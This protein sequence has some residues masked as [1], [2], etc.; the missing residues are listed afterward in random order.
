MSGFTIT[1]RNQH[2]AVE[3]LNS[4]VTASDGTIV[5]TTSTNVGLARSEL[6]GAINWQTKTFR[7][8]EKE[9]PWKEHKRAHAKWK[10]TADWH[11]TAGIV[12]TMKAARFRVWTTPDFAGLRI[13]D[14]GCTPDAEGGRAVWPQP[15]PSFIDLGRSCNERHREN[16][17]VLGTAIHGGSAKYGL[18]LTQRFV[19][20]HRP[21]ASN[22]AGGLLDAD[23]PMYLYPIETHKDFL[24]HPVKSPV[25]MSIRGTPKPH[26]AFAPQTLQFLL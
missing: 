24:E 10:S 2:D 1:P 26:L 23:C 18:D 21:T 15:P 14:R 19:K 8:G 17:F 25:G 20:S 4:T 6:T 13:S 9:R 22:R 5:Y 7:V 11:W 16:V 3:A 12:Y